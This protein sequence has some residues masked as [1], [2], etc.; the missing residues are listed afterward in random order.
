M[1]SD[2]LST[3]PPSRPSL[4][5]IE[6]GSSF[7]TGRYRIQRLLGRGGQKEVY[8]ARDTRLDRDVAIALLNIGGCDE[9][10]V[11]RLRHEAQAMAQLGSHPNIVDVYD[12]GDDRGRPFIVSQYLEGGSV[13][14][15][16]KAT[17][18]RPLALEQVLRIGTQV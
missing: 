1:K 18:G 14:D 9:K 17:P 5:T 2:D 4:P 8:V 12:V 7:S 6:L 13:R 10:N 16:L 15:L 3:L 11:R